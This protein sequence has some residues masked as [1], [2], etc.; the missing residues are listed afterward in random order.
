MHSPVSRFARSR[1]IAPLLVAGL[2]ASLVPVAMSV[3]IASPAGASVAKTDHP[4]PGGNMNGVG[5]VTTLC[6]DPVGFKCTGGGYNGQA[7]QIHGGGWTPSLY[8]VFGTPGPDGSRHNCTTYAAFRLQQAGYDYPGWTANASGWASSA[9]AHKVAVNQTPAV[10]AIAQWNLGH[11]GFVQAVTATAVVIQSDDY[12]GGTDTEEVPFTSPYRPDNYLHFKDVNAAAI[13][14]ITILHKIHV[15]SATASGVSETYW[16]APGHPG[17][18]SDIINRL[19]A[20]AVSTYIGDTS[21]IHVVSA[22]S[23][24]TFETS[25]GAQT[26]NVKR[27]VRLNDVPGTSVATVVGAN[28][29][30]HVFTAAP[31]GVMETWWT[32]RDANER[33][34]V[35]INHLAASSLAAVVKPTGSLAVFSSSSHGVFE[36]TWRHARVSLVTVRLSP[37]ASGAVTAVV[38][39][40]GITHVFAATPAG[41]W[42][43]TWSKNGTTRVTGRIN[44]FD[45]I[46]VSALVSTNGAIHVFTTTPGGTFET[47]WAASLGRGKFTDYVNEL[48]SGSVAAVIAGREDFHVVTVTPSRV[49]ETFWGP[50]LGVRKH[51][52]IV[53]AT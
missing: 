15:F 24:G 12:A 49:V 38:A 9:F 19:D 29:V 50:G 6:N 3:A 25:W 22:T 36:T 7:S 18:Q 31:T 45:A 23:H 30:V 1:K 11:V 17:K 40:S 37:Q 28:G 32:T 47:Y 39:P 21:E 33:H 44:R 26:R 42:Q 5:G 52:A 10:G 4:M 35:W 16:G 53:G 46:G 20:T 27:T 8:W 2:V 14:V 43:T 41:V 13:A 34:S 48:T 51:T